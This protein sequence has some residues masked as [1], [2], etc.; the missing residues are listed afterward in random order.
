MVD[1]GSG[2]TALGLVKSGL[3]DTG[4]RWRLVILM[5]VSFVL[6]WAH[7][8]QRDVEAT[9]WQHQSTHS[10]VA[11]LTCSTLRQSPRRLA[12]ADTL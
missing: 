11:S 3:Y 7:T 4:Q 8:F 9:G 12:L 5:V 2:S 1:T 6:G 10:R